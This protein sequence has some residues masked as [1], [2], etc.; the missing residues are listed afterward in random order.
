MMGIGERLLA[1]HALV[2]A[3]PA[4]VPAIIVVGVV[5][6]IAARDRREE[7]EENELAKQ[8]RSGENSTHADPGHKEQR[9]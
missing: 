5:L 6:Y 1:H 3:I 7:R 8:Q 4:F 2:V 9:G